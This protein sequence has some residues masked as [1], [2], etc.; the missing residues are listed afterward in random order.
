MIGRMRRRRFRGGHRRTS[1]TGT[2]TRAASRNASTR[3]R[4]Q[5]MD[6]T[7]TGAAGRMRRQQDL[8][9]STAGLGGRRLPQEAPHGPRVCASWLRRRVAG[10]RLVRRDLGPDAA[11]PW[12]LPPDTAIG[13]CG[14]VGSLPFRVL[15]VVLLDA[16]PHLFLDRLQGVSR[17]GR[18]AR[19]SGRRRAGGRR[20]CSLAGPRPSSASAAH[21]GAPYPARHRLHHYYHWSVPPTRDQ[22]CR[23]AS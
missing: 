15:L 2:G 21:V 9:R 8:G 10:P 5:G 12:L 14:G 4:T 18:V 3:H 7:G 11:V 20:T 1:R 6:P 17:G 16:S 13:R 19:R 23:P 22:W